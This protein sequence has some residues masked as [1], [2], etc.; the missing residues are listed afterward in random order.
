ME[1]LSPVRR[2]SVPPS[3]VPGQSRPAERPRRFALVRRRMPPLRLELN[4]ILAAVLAVLGLG[5]LGWAGATTSYALFR[6]EF[7]RQ[8]VSRHTANER[9]A[10]AEIARLRDDYERVNSQ[11]L[12]ER[13]NFATEIGELAQ[14]QADVEKRQAVLS[15]LEGSPAEKPAKGGGAPAANEE[16]IGGLRLSTDEPQRQSRAAPTGGAAG[17]RA[18]YDEIEADQR[19]R[20]AAVQTRLEEKRRALNDV[21]AALGLQPQTTK[22]VKAGMGGLYLPFGL[23]GNSASDVDQLTDTAHEMEK[24][25]EGLGRVPV[26]LPLPQLR[27]VS[28]FGNRTD[29]FV[30]GI[31]FH[32]G[33]DLESP[34]GAPAYATAAGTVTA[35]EWNGGYGLMVEIQHDHG[36]ATRYA[37]LSRIAVKQGQDIKAGDVVGF[38]GSTGRSTGPHLH[39][40]TRRND[41]ALNPSR[42]LKIA[43]EIA[44]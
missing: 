42:F 10:R 5:L 12:V 26:G 20:I 3:H 25:R 28:A 27:A 1:P 2:V 13:E 41:T 34:P 31:A 17:L 18:R 36:Y 9:H 24:L 39:Y 38:V 22:P 11:L 16:P 19:Q 32:S 23:G 37:H 29:P 15:Q 43:E 8:L 21:Y 35:A 4:P 30:G 7:L 14:R 44:D 33:I 40:E 6:D